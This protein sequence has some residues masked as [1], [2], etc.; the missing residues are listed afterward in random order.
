MPDYKNEI[1]R[2]GLEEKV[3]EILRLIGYLEDSDDRLKHLDWL[4]NRVTDLES[5]EWISSITSR[6]DR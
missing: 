6:L 4:V 3:T 2:K 1:V 5:D